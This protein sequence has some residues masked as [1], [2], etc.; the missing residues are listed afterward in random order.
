MLT[1]IGIAIVGATK[2]G[3]LAS[4]IFSWA[5]DRPRGTSR[6]VPQWCWRLEV[7][8]YRHQR[9]PRPSGIAPSRR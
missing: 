8:L 5:I 9:M 7:L 6:L 4:V 1:R 3:L 2:F